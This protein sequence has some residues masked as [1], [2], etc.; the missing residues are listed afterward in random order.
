MQ[1]VSDR[2]IALFWLA[3]GSCLGAALASEALGSAALVLGAAGLLCTGL[4]DIEARQQMARQ[5]RNDIP[6]LR[7]VDTLE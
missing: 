4:R 5:R 3:A 7:F 1:N 6:P 2:A